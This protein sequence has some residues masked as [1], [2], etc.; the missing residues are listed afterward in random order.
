MPNKNSCR[1]NV[2]RGYH[3]SVCSVVQPNWDINVRST[4][5]VGVRPGGNTAAWTGR[6]ECRI[7]GNDRIIVRVV[8]EQGSEDVEATG[9]NGNALGRV[10]SGGRVSSAAGTRVVRGVSSGGRVGGVSCG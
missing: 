2:L 10:L 5:V 6:V 7:D 3:D 4:C 8:I 1:I 9:G